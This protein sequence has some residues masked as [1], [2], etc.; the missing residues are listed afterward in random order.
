MESLTNTTMEELIKKFVEITHVAYKRGAFEMVEIP[1]I[2][3]TLQE[4][5]EV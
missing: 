1:Q 5:E 3:A 4:A 2:L